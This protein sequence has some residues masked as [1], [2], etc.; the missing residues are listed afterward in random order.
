M[1]IADDCVTY[2]VSLNK[3]SAF[4][5]E[6]FLADN[7]REGSVKLKSGEV[8]VVTDARYSDSKLTVRRIPKG[9]VSNVFTV[10]CESM[11]LGICS[12]RRSLLT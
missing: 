1:H 5:Y 9:R 8:C 10:P 3:L 4:A 12:I 7:Y 6:N 2:G 11:I